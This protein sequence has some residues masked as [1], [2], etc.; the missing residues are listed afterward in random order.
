LIF[1]CRQCVQENAFRT[2]HVNFAEFREAFDYLFLHNQ[3]S[4]HLPGVLTV[5]G[6]L[7]SSKVMSM[8][9]L[10][11]WLF[12]RFSVRFI[13]RLLPDFIYSRR[14]IWNQA[15]TWWISFASCLVLRALLAAALFERS[16][17]SLRQRAAHWTSNDRSRCVSDH[18]RHCCPHHCRP[19]I[20]ECYW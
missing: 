5:N 18:Q 16:I 3:P 1:S 6:A 13:P 17:S 4:D 7:S 20:I 9:E 15:A 14:S 12:P 11:K 8:L 10:K 2:T 19:Y